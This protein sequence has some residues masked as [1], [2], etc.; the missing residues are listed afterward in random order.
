MKFSWI[1][2][3]ALFAALV[4]GDQ[5]RIGRPDHK[6]R[7][8][9]EVETPDGIKSGSGVMSV[10]PNR[11]YGGS[12]SGETSGPRLKGDAVLVDLGAGR[13]LVALL[14]HESDGRDAEGVVF[15]A[16]RAYVAAGNRIQFREVKRMATAVPVTGDLVP[17]LMTFKNIADPGSARKV[18]PDRLEDTFGKGFR[19]RGISL[20]AARNGFWPLDFGGVL[21][22]PVTR[23]IEMKLPWWGRGDRP[24]AIALNAAGVTIGEASTPEAAF[25]RK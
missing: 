12:G 15:L 22:E 18:A 7:L 1:G 4:I 11:G 5:I 9:V 19:L 10:T 16:M 8:T 2:L 3:L 17:I 14:A 6:Y 23:G 20:T 24:A 21:G 25:T 13:N